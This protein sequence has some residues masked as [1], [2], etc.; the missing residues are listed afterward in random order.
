MLYPLSYEGQRRVGRPSP[1]F[2]PVGRSRA[3]PCRTAPVRARR[4]LEHSFCS[5]MR[6]D[7]CLDVR[8]VGHEASGGP[9]QVCARAICP[10]RG[11]AV[12]CG[13]PETKDTLTVCVV[14]DGST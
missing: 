12:Y 13:G 3:R 5:L 9:A 10:C 4:N 14:P 1:T 8:L 11:V 6:V 2:L 7:G